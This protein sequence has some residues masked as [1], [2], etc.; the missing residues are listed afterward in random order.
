MA[1][2]DISN[3]QGLHAVGAVVVFDNGQPDKESYRHYRLEGKTEPDDPAMMAEV[4][5]RFQEMT[6]DLALKLDLLVLDGGKGQLN[7][8][9][10]LFEKLEM[11]ARR[12]RDCPGQRARG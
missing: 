4:L 6:P 7:R 8:M 3:L 9:T 2:V 10:R 12:P 11:T 5:E 1:C